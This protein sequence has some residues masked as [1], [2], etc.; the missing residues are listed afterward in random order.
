[1]EKEQKTISKKKWIG[2]GIL[3][4]II[5]AVTAGIL[6]YQLSPKQ[7]CYRHIKNADKYLVQLEYEQAVVEYTKAFSIMPNDS[8]IRTK[9]ADAYLMWAD[10]LL[11]A[12]EMDAAK[13]VLERG[14]EQLQDGRIEAT[15]ERIFFS[16]DDEDADDE[17]KDDDEE[18]EL[19]AGKLKSVLTLDKETELGAGYGGAIPYKKDGLFGAMDYQGNNIVPCEYD[20]FRAPN[21]KG[22]LVMIKNKEGEY[23]KDYTVFDSTGKKILNVSDH[24]VSVIASG[25]LIIVPRVEEIPDDWIS[26]E[27]FYVD[28]YDYSGKLINSVKCNSSY[29][30]SPE[31]V[32]DGKAILM[33]KV[34]NAGTYYPTR[35]RYARSYVPYEYG[36]A[37]ADGS[38]EWIDGDG[39][40]EED[41]GQTESW[42]EHR[43]TITSGNGWQGANGSGDMDYYP[44]G[45]INRGFFLS[46]G[47]EGSIRLIDEEG[48]IHSDV[49]F[50][51]AS[52]ANDY[53]TFRTS[54]GDSGAYEFMEYTPDGDD[55]TY[56][57][58]DPFYYDGGYVYNYGSKVVLKSED[59][60]ALLDLDKLS[61]KVQLVK[62]DFIKLSN[63]KYWLVS[64]NDKWGYCDHDGNIVGLYEDASAFYNG[65]AMIIENGI[66][67]LID[68]QLNK[69]GEIGEAD[70]VSQIGSLFSIEKNGNRMLYI[71]E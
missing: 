55:Y 36:F 20:D 39:L 50:Y 6:A 69:V 7:Q 68:A 34:E 65:Y 17:N 41:S 60:Y 27:E 54:E 37:S 23:Y 21:E 12:G 5:I 31:G 45:P 4:L 11:A 29:Y 56:P 30:R 62:F 25:D 64:S 2:F 32:V 59:G 58:M 49:H 71:I 40:D 52:L 14:L 26:W 48:K 67:Y 42:E 28:Y 9:L 70:A 19:V 43:A 61:E 66:A 22:Y 18:D 44:L 53:I 3:A 35:D 13:A 24:I 33:R 63:E 1:M 16:S 10:S 46:C 57:W 38:I 51:G 15:Y 47:I 8:E